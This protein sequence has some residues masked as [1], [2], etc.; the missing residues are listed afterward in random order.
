MDIKNITIR[1]KSIATNKETLEELVTYPNFPVFIGCTDQTPE[2][3]LRADMKW[4]ICKESG[5]I[6]LYEL[7]PQ[8]VIYSQYHSEAIGGIWEQHHDKFCEFI[9]R[10]I[11]GNVIEIGG[12]NGSLADKYLKNHNN[13]EWTIVEPGMKKNNP[14]LEK[15]IKF[16]NSFFNKKLN[17]EKGKSIIHSHAF[18]HMYQ[19]AE[20]LDDI[21]DY[22]DEGGRQVFSVPNLTK[23]LENKYSNSINFE[24][25]FYFTEE[26]LEYL[27]STRKYKIIEK[28]YFREHSIFYSVE[29]DISVKAVHLGN[30]YKYYRS[31]VLCCTPRPTKLLLYL[32]FAR[33]KKVQLQTML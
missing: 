4:M 13:I 8:D 31:S 7:M 20:F 3:D 29:K 32:S 5:C 6:Q 21:S 26:L 22:L 19:P 9:F 24:H 28:E 1:S 17:L 11:S 2:K 12:S 27:L 16:I 23:Y 30:Q 10:N 33:K 25:T 15:N 14:N 18:E